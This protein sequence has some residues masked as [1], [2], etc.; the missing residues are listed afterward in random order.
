MITSTL[1]TDAI[2]YFL[3]HV[4]QGILQV[5]IA[6]LRSILKTCP[7]LF[8]VKEVKYLDNQQTSQLHLNYKL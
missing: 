8:Q 6:L 5:R 1:L 2:S 4:S 7:S 3:Y